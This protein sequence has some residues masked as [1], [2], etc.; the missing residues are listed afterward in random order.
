MSKKCIRLFI[1]AIIVIGLLSIANI[2]MAVEVTETEK[3]NI[4][5]FLEDNG[6]L[7]YYNYNKVEDICITPE[8]L[9]KVKK[10]RITEA[11]LKDTEIYEMVEDYEEARMITKENLNSYLYSTIGISMDKLRNYEEFIKQT[12]TTNNKDQFFY[13]VVTGPITYNDYEITKIEQTSDETIK[14]TI[15]AKA[16]EESFSNVIELAKKDNSYNFVSST[17]ADGKNRAFY[18]SDKN[19]FNNKNEEIK[20]PVEEVKQPVKETVKEEEPKQDNTVATKELAKAGD[21]ANI[22]VIS[23]ITMIIIVAI[24]MFVAIIFIVNYKK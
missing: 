23:V 2:S 24:I 12:T 6:V 10:E 3:S 21:N 9:Q 13:L 17:S 5:K 22:A 4:I 20:Q 1:L 15:T 18:V 11:Q 16:A 8:L 14:V 19:E 7:S